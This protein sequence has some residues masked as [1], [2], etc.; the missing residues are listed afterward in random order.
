M[1]R[2]TATNRYCR[3]RPRRRLCARRQHSASPCCPGRRSVASDGERQRRLS[4]CRAQIDAPN[5]IGARGGVRKPSPTHCYGAASRATG[6]S[7][8]LVR[9]V[10]RGQRSDIFRTRESSLE[11]HLPWLDAQWPPEITMALNCGG[12]CKPPAFVVRCELFP[13]GHAVDDAPKRWMKPARAAR[14]RPER[15][16]A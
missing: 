13:N 3:A 2:R 11:P 7:R 6:H 4:R 10:L 15:S 12:I 1:V 16:R 9:K 8:G 5:T 14:P